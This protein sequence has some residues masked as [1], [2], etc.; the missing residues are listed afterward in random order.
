MPW[1]RPSCTCIGALALVTLAGSVSQ[2]EA[3][4]RLSHRYGPSGSQ[5]EVL[6]GSGDSSLG[7]LAA[8]ALNL[9]GRLES[10]VPVRVSSHTVS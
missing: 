9:R 4:Q 7:L 5:R 1:R 6:C 2:R 8:A 10:S 3:P